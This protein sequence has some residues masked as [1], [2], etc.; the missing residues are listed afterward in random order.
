MVTAVR[1]V[2]GDIAPGDLGV[3]DAHDHLFLAVPSLA[4]QELDDPAAAEAEVEVFAG[5]GGAAV[6]QWTPFGLGRA[7]GRLPAIAR[8]TGVHVVAATGLHQAH[9]YDPALLDRLSRDGLAAFFVAELTEGML[10]GDTPDAPRGTARAGMIK[11]AGGFHGLDDHARRMLTAAAEAHHA[12]GAPIGVHHEMG[13]AAPDVLD[14]LHGRLGVPPS[15]LLLGH[16]NRF[17]DP[18]LHRELAASGAFLAFDGPSRAHH[19][20]DWRLLAGLV[21]LAEAGHLHQ[22]LLGG[23]TVTA[24]ARATTG[25]GPGMPYLL[26]T[27]RPRLTRA[28]GEEA[29]TAVF[30][31]NPARA[32]SARWTT[33]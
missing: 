17:P 32:F 30:R 31:T 13:T 23:D 22:L 28:L 8:A 14:L 3:T 19:A 16:L 6:A 27:L 25:E 12:T 1:T 9:H 5:L 33:P 20:T 15:A 11:V 21:A 2:L 4:G 10:D 7:A 29:A 26:R 18:G 24:T